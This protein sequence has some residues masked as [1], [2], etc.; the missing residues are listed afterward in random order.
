MEKQRLLNAIKRKE[1]DRPPCICPG[2]MMNYAVRELMEWKQILLPAAHADAKAMADLAAAAYEARCFENYGVPFCMTI[3]AEELGARVD[4]GNDCY[5][6][7]I[8]EYAISSV[9]EWQ[10]L[11]SVAHE[12]ARKKV[13]TDA[14]GILKQ[15]SDG[16]P[17]VANLTG[18]V[19]VASSLMEPTVFYKELRKKNQE[20]H[21]LMGFVTGRL[22]EFGKAQLSAGADVIAISDPSGTGE[23]MGPKLFEEFTV[24][25]INALLAGLREAFPDIPAIVHICGRMHK[26]YGLLN[27]LECDALSFDALVNLVQARG[28]LP[29]HA[30]MGNVSTYAIEHGTPEKVARL[31]QKAALDGADIVAPACGLGNSSPLANLQAMLIGLTSG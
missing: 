27:K 18:P 29:K 26:V 28:H 25:Y 9:C 16:V 15:K 4:M 7:R 13:V 2:G 3:E 21:E 30:I 20:S 8:S 1:N 22:I 19:S 17:I 10:K 11:R 31:A 5:E 23:I 24:Q 14:I 6:P 12:N